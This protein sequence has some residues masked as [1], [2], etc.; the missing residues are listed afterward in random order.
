MLRVLLLNYEIRTILSA[1]ILLLHTHLICSLFAIVHHCVYAYNIFQIT[2]IPLESKCNKL[3][4]VICIS[5][6]DVCKQ[7]MQYYSNVLQQ[8]L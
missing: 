3:Q 7:D 8:N 5:S 2:F 1:L 4:L 6:I